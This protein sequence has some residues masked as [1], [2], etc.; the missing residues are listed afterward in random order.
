MKKWKYLFNCFILTIPILIWNMVL[1][2]KLPKEFQPEIFWNNIPTSLTYGENV[3]RIAVFFITFLMPLSLSSSTQKKGLLIYLIGILLYFSSWLMLIYFPDST[4]ANSMLGFLSPAFTP[5]IWL[6]G[7]GLIGNSFYFNLPFRR[8]FFILL[9]IVFLLFH[10]V[11]TYI[12]YSRTQ[13]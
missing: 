2:N 7:I 13:L 4:L 6:V 11:H 3:S 8:W 1:A 5:L 10:N 9:S 12:I